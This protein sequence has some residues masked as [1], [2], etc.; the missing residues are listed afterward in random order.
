M[1]F[2]VFRRFEDHNDGRSEIELSEWGAFG[3]GDRR[4]KGLP[5]VVIGATRDRFLPAPREIGFERRIEVGFD[6]ADV[7]GA[8]R[9]VA[10]E[11]VLP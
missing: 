3:H 8:D 4:R 11:A 1:K 5:A 10:K 7:G 6:G 2:K 9:S